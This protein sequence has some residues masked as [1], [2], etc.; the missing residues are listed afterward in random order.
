MQRMSDT[1]GEMLDEVN[2][3]FDNIESAYYEIGGFSIFKKYTEF[4]S[5]HFA[6]LIN[7]IMF[8]A[9]FILPQ[10]FLGIDMVYFVY[11]IFENGAG[12][13]WEGIF[14]K[15]IWALTW[16]FIFNLT[17]FIY[18]YR[19]IYPTVYYAIGFL[20]DILCTIIYITIAYPLALLYE[21][22]YGLLYKIF[23]W[24]VFYTDYKNTDMLKRD[25][26][27][28]MEW[29]INRKIKKEQARRESIIKNLTPKQK[30][31]WNNLHL[32]HKMYEKGFEYYTSFLDWV[33]E[34]EGR[35]GTTFKTHYDFF[36][37]MED[38]IVRNYNLPE[39]CRMKNAKNCKYAN[40]K[41]YYDN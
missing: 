31:G 36:K 18:I 37:Y 20:T 13:E 35:Y 25:T 24:E 16:M 5:V 3:E 14:Y 33:E 15:D 41:I 26:E 10:F 19:F 1:S 17:I 6:Y 32:F 9:L 22:V 28:I 27:W 40:Y 4:D 21:C 12:Q 29:I 30:E 34:E 2:D 11:L 39:E 23:G 7:G 8:F 38:R